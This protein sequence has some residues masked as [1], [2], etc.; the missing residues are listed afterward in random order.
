MFFIRPYYFKMYMNIEIELAKQK[1]RIHLHLQDTK[2]YFKSFITNEDCDEWDV[3]VEEEDIQRYP[4]ICP[5]GVLS[6]FSEAYLLIPRVS[7]FLLKEKCALIHGASFVWH[8]KSYLITAP[9]GT[10]KTTQLHNWI[11]LFGNEIELINGDKTVVSISDDMR[12][13]LY[14][15]PWTGKEKESGYAYAPLGGILVLKQSDNNQIRRI[16]PRESVLEIF[17]QFLNVGDS[18]EEVFAIGELT[19]YLLNNIPIWL[20]ENIGDEESTK[21]AYQTLLEFE[22]ENNEKD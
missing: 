4:L 11:K 14:P 6:S 22:V 5:S 13:W 17:Q 9:S 2:K 21:L 12:V 3:R 15:S 7:A 1:V 10:G 19:D 20:L 18:S 16:E 8:R